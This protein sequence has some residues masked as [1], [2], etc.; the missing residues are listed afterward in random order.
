MQRFCKEARSLAIGFREQF[1]MRVGAVLLG[2]S[3]R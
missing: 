2:V 3:A 1:A